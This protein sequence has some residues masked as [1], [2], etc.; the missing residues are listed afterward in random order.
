MVYGDRN[1]GLQLSVF[2]HFNYNV[3]VN[4]TYNVSRNV[5]LFLH[6]SSVSLAMNT[7]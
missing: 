7:L 5:H 6:S 4:L 1:D 3:H 2:E